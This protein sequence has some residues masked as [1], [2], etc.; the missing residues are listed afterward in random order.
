MIAHTV[1]GVNSLTLNFLQDFNL[2]IAGYPTFFNAETT[3]CN[4]VSFRY[5]GW[6][7]VDRTDVW[8][9]TSLRAEMNDLVNSLNKVIEA[10]VLETNQLLNRNVTH[11]VDVNPYF[12][13]H[14]WCE[15]GVSEPD[16]TSTNTA[17]FLSGWPDVQ[18][19]ATV[20]TAADE[21]AELSGLSADGSLPLPDGYTCNTTLGIDPDPVD[22]YWC[23]IASAVV[24][25]PDGDIAQYVA[26]ANT[27]LA[28]GEVSAENIAWFLPLSQIK[29]F[30][31]RSIGQA[32]YRDA[33]LAAKEQ[34]EYG[35]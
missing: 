23:D 2:Y 20:S 30:H 33:I 13:G 25:D 7:K 9:S 34:V 24:S 14:R 8:L 35:Y 27:A 29:T 1:Q 11:F 22:V 17:F 3:A 28:S 10:A 12:D 16:S 32:F 6:T 21:S 19:G 15:D 18:E 26:L 4:D 31:P 5:W